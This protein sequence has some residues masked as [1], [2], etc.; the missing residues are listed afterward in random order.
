MRATGWEALSI[1][2]RVERAIGEARRPENVRITRCAALMPS[3]GRKSRHPV[4]AIALHGM[5]PASCKSL[6]WTAHFRMGPLKKRVK[7]AMNSR[8]CHGHFAIALNHAT[9]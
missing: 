6:F 3:L 5:N 4:Q 2:A 7:Q 8:S 1:L 9:P